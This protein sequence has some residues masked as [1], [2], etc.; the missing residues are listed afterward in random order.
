MPFATSAD[1]TRIAYTAT[2]SGPAL[3]LVDGALCHRGFGPSPDLVK[4]FSSDFTVYAYDRR[5]RGESGDTA[6]YSVDKEI[7]D[8]AA[9][10]D[11]AGGAAAV[12]GLSSGGV[13]ALDAANRLD[14]ITKAA[15]YECPFIVDDTHAPR[16]ASLIED[17]DAMIAQDRRGDAVTSF[18]RMV[19]TP[20]F[21]V[22]VMKLMPMWKKLK[23]VAP[24]LRY[25]YRVLGE[26]GSGKPLPQDRWADA[27]QPVL[28]MD[29]GKSPDYLRNAMRML[30]DTLP[31]AEHRTLPGQTHMV[32]PEIL[33]PVV[34]EFLLRD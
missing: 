17:M 9:V 7:D 24:T 27:K 23:A 18:M 25:D 30:A 29:G 3:V 33:S 31:T 19:G 21:A 20:G 8:I 22:M 28:A 5:G 16:P 1:G 10:I 11:A 15:V 34:T 4:A 14:S 6:P 13:L 12:L 26:T 32:K 2:G